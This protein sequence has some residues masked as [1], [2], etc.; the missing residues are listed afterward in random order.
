[1]NPVAHWLLSSSSFLGTQVSFT[2]SATLPNLQSRD[3]MILS[4]WQAKLTSKMFRIDLLHRC[5]QKNR[6]G[7]AVKSVRAK[8]VTRTTAFSLQFH[9]VKLILYLTWA[10]PPKSTVKRLGDMLKLRW[11]MAAKCLDRLVVVVERCS[12]NCSKMN[13]V[14]HY[15][16]LSSSSFLG[17]QVSFTWSATLPNLQSRDWMILSLWQ[18]KL[19]SKLFG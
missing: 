3:W 9:F 5:L 14:A 18:A 15:W 2:W 8:M 6:L 1:M 4:L 10:P 16:L 11:K 17:T 19:T 13:P 7:E 12:G